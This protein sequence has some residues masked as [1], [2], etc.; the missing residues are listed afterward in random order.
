M[1]PEP[2]QVIWRWNSETDGETEIYNEVI[3]NVG[4]TEV[5]LTFRDFDRELYQ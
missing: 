5:R 1:N 3:N 2:L 4:L